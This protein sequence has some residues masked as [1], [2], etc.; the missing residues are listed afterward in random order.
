VNLKKLLALLLVLAMV[1]AVGCSGGGKDTAGD[2]ATD[3]P[4]ESKA[5]DKSGDTPSGDT[6]SGDEAMPEEGPDTNN[7][8]P[9]NLAPVKYD[10]RQ[11]KYLNGINATKL[12]VTTDDVTLVIWQSHNS[13]VMQELSESEAYKELEKR[14]GVK[15]EWVYP[16]V[17]QETDNFNL[18]VSSLD[19]PHVFVRPPAYQGGYQKAVADGIYME[20]T[21]YYDKGLMPNF[22]WI[23]EN[24]EDINRDAVDDEG[25][26]YFFP[27]L[28]IVPT[29]P[30][31]GL[32]VREDWV[33][34]LGLE[35]PKTI[36]D[37]DNM[38]RKMK[39]AKGL[40]PLGLNVT[41][42][43]GVA[44]NYMF[45]G[46]YETGYNFINK[47]NK[48]EW[49]PINAG[50]KNFLTLLN[51]WYADGLIDPDFATR[52][53][54]SYA[55]NLANS[56]YGAVG[57]AYGELGQAKVSGMQQDPNWKLTPVLMPTSSDGQVIHLHQDNATVRSSRNYFTTR[58]LDDNLAEVAVKWQDYWY[59]QDG[60]DL[61]SYGPEGV[62]YKWNDKGEVEWIYPRLKNDEGLDF[63]TLYPLFKLHE[64]SYLRDSSSYEFEP[65]VFEC[66]ELWDSQDSSWLVPENMSFTADENKELSAIMTDINTLRDEMT[67][68]FI[69]GQEP[70]DK[71]D[72]FVETIKGMNI[73]RAVEIYQAALDRYNK[74]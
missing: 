47:E 44:T 11:D 23:R 5:P 53:S 9:Y 8:R 4:A 52:D 41:S 71:F 46:S 21:E 16:P 28:D 29:D 58:I 31:S 49:G 64:G 60:G 25:K 69:L 2:K 33:K 22:Q 55:A 24:R 3:K 68:K 39:E 70:L 43:Y 1:F 54:D 72:S 12:P 15:I 26:M 50:Y 37:W 74:R 56:Q 38:L 32:W 61:L 36:D 19:L 40:A 6:A 73:D 13:T 57:L 51:K 59:S 67:L 42:W 27:M 48:I 35:L 18:R 65:E 63:W 34:E 20:L 14:T 45:A 17:G 30:W 66:I 7:G 62:S 10:N